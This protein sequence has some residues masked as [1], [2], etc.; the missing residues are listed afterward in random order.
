M[1]RKIHDE[2]L[3]SIYNKV[4]QNPGRKPGFI[5]HLLGINRS[6]VTR[7]LPALDK[8]GLFLFEDE[9]GGLWPFRKSKSN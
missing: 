7:S 4:S 2:K 1:V 8:R 5:A 6:D 3:E 9:K